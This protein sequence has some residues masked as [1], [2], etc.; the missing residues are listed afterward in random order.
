MT[1]EML[2]CLLIGGISTLAIATCRAMSIVEPE[3]N[4]YAVY[5][6]AVNLISVFLYGLAL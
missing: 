1:N 2:R 6:A 4:W 5:V 3:N